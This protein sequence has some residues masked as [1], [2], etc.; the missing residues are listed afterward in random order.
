MLHVVAEEKPEG[1]HNTDR[2]IKPAPEEHSMSGGQRLKGRPSP[3]DYIRITGLI[4]FG[5]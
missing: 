4:C 1:P 2:N 3:N 5:I